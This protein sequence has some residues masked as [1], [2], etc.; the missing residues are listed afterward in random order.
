MPVG[1]YK[2]IVEIKLGKKKNW[3]QVRAGRLGDF[4]FSD[5]L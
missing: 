3:R 1:K 2:V 4:G 5:G